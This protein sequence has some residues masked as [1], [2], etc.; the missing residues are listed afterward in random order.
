M[1]LCLTTPGQMQVE[2]SAPIGFYDSLNSQPR[3]QIRWRALLGISFQLTANLLK[4]L[5][6]KSGI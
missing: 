1:V 2:P 4:P 5:N 6:L 3:R